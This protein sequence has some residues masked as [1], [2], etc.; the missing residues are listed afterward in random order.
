MLKIQIV[1]RNSRNQLKIVDS[2][3]GNRDYINTII[4]EQNLLFFRE[5]K[6]CI[7]KQYYYIL[8]F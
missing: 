6:Q 5:L 1:Y 7:N 2:K 3:Q 4:K 8:T